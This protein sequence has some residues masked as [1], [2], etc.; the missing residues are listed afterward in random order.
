MAKSNFEMFVDTVNS[1]A[2]SQGFYSR[3]ASGIA[4]MSEHELSELKEH[5]NGLDVQF[6]NPV[7]VVMFLET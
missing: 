7:D 5:L 4:D 2:G 1:L 3:I 6:T